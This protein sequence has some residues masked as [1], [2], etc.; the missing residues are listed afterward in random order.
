MLCEKPLAMSA[1]EAQGTGEIW[2]RRRSWRNCLNHNLRFY[3]VVQQI[4]GDDREAGELGEILVV[5]GTYSQDWLLYDTDWNWRIV[6][7]DNGPLRVMG[8]HRLALDGHDQHLTGLRS[9]R[10]APTCRRSTRRASGPRG[11]VETFAGKT[12][13]PEDYEEVPI[14]TEDFGAVLLTLGDRA[15]GAFTVSQMNV[16]LQEPLP[17]RDLRN[18]GRRDLEPGAA[19]R[20]VDRPS[21]RAEPD[22]REGSVA[23]A[24]R[25]R[26]RY[27]DLPGGHS[28][29][30]DDTHKQC[31]RRFYARVADPS[32]PVEY[33]TFEDGYQ[34]MR[35]SRRPSRAQRSARGWTWTRKEHS[36]GAGLRPCL[37]FRPVS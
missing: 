36:A 31:F 8:G 3:P 19:G 26:A 7:K 18:E 20:A 12:L 37:L 13:K 5:Q 25:R 33:P 27:A 6:A 28:E 9:R 17:D 24:I 21:Q 4:R 16:G 30:Y 2:R 23:A 1:A 11:P 10:C 35:F 15:R 29:G 22:H 14:D 34:M 32:A